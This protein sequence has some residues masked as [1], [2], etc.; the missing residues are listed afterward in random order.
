MAKL[1]A[2]PLCTR[3]RGLPRHLSLHEHEDQNENLWLTQEVRRAHKEVRKNN[4]H[5]RN[6]AQSQRGWRP[7]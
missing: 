4:D 7:H 2:R 6:H 5:P 3:W 1:T